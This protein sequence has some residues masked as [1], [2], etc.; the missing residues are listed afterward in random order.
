MRSRPVI[1]CCVLTSGDKTRQRHFPCTQPE[2]TS[3][4]ISYLSPAWLSPNTENRKSI[5]RERLPSSQVRDCSMS[6]VHQFCEVLSCRHHWPRW[7]LS[8]R[9]RLSD[10]LMSIYV[11]NRT[12]L[13]L[14]KGYQVHGI[15]R[16]SSSFNTGRLHHLYEVS[17]L[18]SLMDCPEIV[19]FP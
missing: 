1:H 4:L 12:E 17:V 3:C 15:I 16:R 9:A 7:V 18:S 2:P 19:T 8:V 10:S 11:A 6:C 5:A 14:E 13:L